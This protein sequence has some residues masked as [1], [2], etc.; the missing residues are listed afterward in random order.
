MKKALFCIMLWLPLC[1]VA[2]RGVADTAQQVVERYLRLLNYEALPADSMLVARTVVTFNDG[3]DSLIMHRWLAP[4]GR[5]RVEVWTGD[6]QT[7]G[8]CTNGK[9]RH[10]H[11]SPKL[12]WW[13][14]RE[15]DE[16]LRLL[17]PYELRGQLY[18]WAGRNVKLR[19]NG[20][21]DYRGQR[22]DVVA[23]EQ[24][25]FYD[26]Y[27]FFEEN[28]GLLVLV[29]ELESSS[30][31]TVKSPGDIMEWKIIHEYQPIGTSLIVS[32]ESFMRDGHIFIMYTT[33]HF[34]PVYDLLFNS[35]L[36]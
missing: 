35:D 28:S 16:I 20:V 30:G 27:Y 8:L 4:G 5:Q 2:Q 33:A 10:R 3:A 18:N 22:L 24:L 7:V 21:G 29:R 6:E 26:R 11:F 17:Q 13:Q 12:G 1:V 32:Q 36:R 14:D 34:E 25:G 19:Y 15:Q 23:A 31:G 9:E